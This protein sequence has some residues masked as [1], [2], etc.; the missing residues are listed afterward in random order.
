MWVSNPLY[1]RIHPLIVV[2]LAYN[3]LDVFTEEDRKVLRDE[4]THKWKQT[5]TLYYVSCT[6]ILI[7]YGAD[8][9]TADGS[10]VIVGGCRT[11]YG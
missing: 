10:H 11:G 2:A 7:Y 9:R 6:P 3:H 1:A 8:I 5:K 4:V